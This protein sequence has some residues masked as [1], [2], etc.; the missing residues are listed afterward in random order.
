MTVVAFVFQLVMGVVLTA[1]VVH[2]DMRRLGP[3][4]LA[5]AW[6]I[7]SFWS[8]VVAF[9]P[10]CVPVHFVRTRRSVLGFLVGVAWATGLLVALGLASDALDRVVA[11]IWP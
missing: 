7:A 1:K 2:W 9:G 5:R 6:N 8:A 4:R 3:E 10:L 11:A